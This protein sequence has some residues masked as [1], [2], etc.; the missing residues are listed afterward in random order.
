MATFEAANRLR[1][2]GATALEEY[3]DVNNLTVVRL[4]TSYVLLATF[5][6]RY[7]KR[8]PEDLFIDTVR[9][10]AV[11]EGEDPG[12]Q[13]E[14]PQNLQHED[15]ALQYL[16]SPAN[17]DAPTPPAPEENDDNEKRVKKNDSKRTSRD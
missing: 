6:G 2:E 8:P 15:P 9:V 4:D 17:M 10:I 5:S 1:L 14:G 12:I 11:K 16:D 7:K 13:A 3:G